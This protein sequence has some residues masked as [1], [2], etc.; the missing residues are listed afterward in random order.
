MGSML[1]PVIQEGRQQHRETDIGYADTVPVNVITQ[2]GG[3][4]LASGYKYTHKEC[5]NRAEWIKQCLV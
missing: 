4:I 5:Q 2:E 1:N 3:I